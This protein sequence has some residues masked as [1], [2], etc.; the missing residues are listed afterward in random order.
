MASWWEGVKHMLG[1]HHREPPTHEDAEAERKRL[2]DE[3]QRAEAR[4]RV[5]ALDLRVEV[6]TRRLDKHE[7]RPHG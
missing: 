7:E 6:L 5:A 4:R 2:A 3:R 1:F